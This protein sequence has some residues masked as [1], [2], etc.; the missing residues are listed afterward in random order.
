MG[1]ARQNPAYIEQIQATEQY[2]MSTES[3]G[4]EEKKAYVCE[5]LLPLTLRHAVGGG[6]GRLLL[7]HSCLPT[8]KDAV[9]TDR[10]RPR[11][12]LRRVKCKL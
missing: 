1:Y 3:K 7:G 9:R 12:E 11:I 2:G 4:E 6:T 10:R 8:C 5:R